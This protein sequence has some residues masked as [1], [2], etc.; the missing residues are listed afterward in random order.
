MGEN[1][2]KDRRKT[3]DDL[4]ARLDLLIPGSGFSYT[5]PPPP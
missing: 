2:Q 4:F 1:K 3:E 5:P